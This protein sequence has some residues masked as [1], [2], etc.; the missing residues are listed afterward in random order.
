MLEISNIKNIT[1]SVGD[2][3][4]VLHY[5]YYDMMRKIKILN[6]LSLVYSKVI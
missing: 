5:L 4:L 6:L 1:M 2:I 3:F